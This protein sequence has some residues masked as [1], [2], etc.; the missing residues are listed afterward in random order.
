MKTFFINEAIDK[1][2]NDYLLSKDKE[3]SVLY[4]SFLVVIIRLLVS[5]YG[6]LD[7]INPF[8]MN[9]EAAFDANLMKFGAKKEEIDNLKRLIDGFLVIEKKN[10][11]SLKR[12]VN[13]YFIETQ[14]CIIDLF[15]LKRINFGLNEKENREFFDLLYTPGSKNALRLSYNY[16]N[17]ENIYEVAEYYKN[18]MAEKVN[19]KDEEEHKNLLG[20]DV[21]K[22]F[23][24]SIA[25]LSKMSDSDVD[26]LNSEIYESFDINENSINKDYLLKQRIK[27][28]KMQNNPITTGNGYV[29]ILLIMSVVI[30]IVMIVVIFGTL[31][32]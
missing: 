22:L 19:E 12:E 9:S 31:V 25:D 18:K 1:A 32:F 21:Y 10:V 28:I 16:L 26:K 15:N 3:E 13:S 30:T 23:N 11:K 4:N 17:A 2:V 6:E 20:F 29:D 24:V 8:R 7:I 14:K 5:I 27:E